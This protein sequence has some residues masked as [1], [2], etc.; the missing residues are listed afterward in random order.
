MTRS[1]SLTKLTGALETCA[2]R[3]VLSQIAPRSPQLRAHLQRRFSRPA[4]EPDGF[5]AEPVLEANFGWQRAEPTIADLAGSLLH[6]ALVE[7]MDRPPAG[8][9]REENR[10]AKTWSPYRHQ[11]AAWQALREEPAGS[12]LVSSGTGSGKTECFLVPVLDA[13]GREAEQQ[14]QPLVGVRALFLYPLNALI[15]SQRDR[16]RAWTH[17]FGGKLRFCLYNGET[18]EAIRRSDQR[19][20]VAEVLD[21]RTL[22]EDTPPILVT[23]TTMLEY[24]LVRRNDAPIIRAS[25]GQL[26]WIV[27]DEAH[28]YLGSQA[29]EL[30]LLLRRVLHAFD[31]SPEQVRFVATSATISSEGGSDVE[32]RLAD[33][34]AD[35]AGIPSASVSVITG[36]RRVP[37]LPPELAARDEALP[38]LDDLRRMAGAGR[39]SEL[40]EALASN[41]AVRAMRHEL[42]G[43]VEPNCKLTEL[44]QVVERHRGPGD[45]LLELLDLCACAKQGDE[46]LLPIRTH[47]FHRT[48]RGLWACCNPGCSGRGGTALDDPLWPFGKVFLDRWQECDEP[49]C[50]SKVFQL[51]LCRS[52]GSEYLLAEME[53]EEGRQRLVPATSDA[54]DEDLAADDMGDED[55]EAV[56]EAR[57]RKMSLRR[58]LTGPDA[59]LTGGLKELLCPISGELGAGDGDRHQVGL[60][61]TNVP[62]GRED[63]RVSCPSCNAHEYEPEQVF[64]P[65]RA[66]APFFLSSAIP[67]LL[68][69]L[70][71]P[72]WK[73][74]DPRP[75]NG[76]RL[77]T[78]SDS[79]QGTARFA[80]R[81]QSESERNYVRSWL[82]HQ[83]LAQRQIA[84]PQEI[85]STR[86]RI[87]AL[88][89]AGAT[90]NPALRG[91]LEAEQA[92][93]N[94]LT[95]PA[96]GR[97][98][99]RQA[100][101]DLKQD[102][103]IRRWLNKLWEDQAFGAVTRDKLPQL[104]LLR[105]L[106]RRPKW[107][108]SL[109]TLGL[110]A[111]EYPRCLEA[112]P[113]AA[114]R[115][116]GLPSRDWHDFLT[117]AVDHRVRAY[118]AVDVPE[119]FRHWL[120]VRI[121]PKVLL[122]PG[123][124][125]TANDQILWPLARKS[126]IRHRLTWLLAAGLELDLS[127]QEHRE[128]LSEL[129][130]AAWQ[131]IR[132]MLS[133][134]GGGW[135]LRLEDQV[136]LIE[137]QHAWRCPVTRRL[138]P[139]SFRGLTPYL[140]S[141]NSLAADCEKVA[142]P[143]VPRP[144]WRDE[145]DRRWSREEV[146]HWLDKDPSVVELRDR[147]LWSDLSDRL[148]AGVD[149]YRAA[150]HSAQQS[151][152]RLQELEKEFKDGRVNLLSCSTT[153]EMGVDIGG[154]S[155]VAMNNTPPSPANFLQRAGRAGR[156]GEAVAVSFTLCKATPHGE[157]VFEN[158]LW[159][160]RTPIYVPRVSLDSERIVERHVNAMVL[161][162][163]F[164]D[165]GSEVE[166]L[167]LDAGWFFG[168]DAV[169]TNT[170]AESFCDVCRSPEMLEDEKLK[171][172][173]R[174]LLRRTAHEDSPMEELL[175]QSASTIE[176][177]KLDFAKERDN[178]LKDLKSVQSRHTGK[179]TPEQKAIQF[180]LQRFLGEYL[181]SELASRGYLPGYGFPTHVVPFVHTTAKQFEAERRRRQEK[182]ARED[183]RALRRSYPSR[184]LSIALRD[185]APGNE[186]V[187]DGRVYRSEG[188]TLNWHVPPSD[189]EFREPQAFPVAWRC[190]DCHCS[191]TRPS[192]HEECPACGAGKDRL[193]QRSFL[194]PAGF[195]V[196]IR[197]Q[198]HNDLSYPP[199]LPVEEPWISAAGESWTDLPD[200]RWGSFRYSPR[201]HVFHYSKGV[202]GYGYAICLSCGRAESEVEPRPREG[203][204]PLP[205]ALPGHKRL[206]G[207][208][209]AEGT[210]LCPG[211]TETRLVKRWQWLGASARTDVFELQ[212]HRPTLEPR[213][214]AYSVAVA[215][216]EALAEK[217]GIDPREI[218]CAAIEGERQEG[219]PR[220]YSIVLYDT[221]SGGAGFV[222]AAA[223]HLPELLVAARD[224]L[225]DCP[226]RCNRA[227]HAC[228]LTYDSQ[229][230][231]DLLDRKI[232]YEA[233]SAEMIASL[234]LPRVQ[235]YFGSTSIAVFGTLPEAVR[236]EAQRQQI[237]QVEIFLGGDGSRWEIARWNLYRHLLGWAESKHVRLVLDRRALEQISPE[238]SWV[239]AGLTRVTGID[240]TSV[241]DLPAAPGGGVLLAR[242]GDGQQW[243]AWAS[244]SVT[245]TEPGEAW[246][247]LGDREFL[248][249]ADRLP[250]APIESNPVAMR[251]L[252]RPYPGTLI[253]MKILREL[254]GPVSRFGE[255]LWETLLKKAPSLNV[256]LNG[257]EP[258]A[259]ISYADRYLR[260][261]LTVKL[262]YEVVRALERRKGLPAADC[263]IELH[264][265]PPRANRPPRRACD[266]WVH[267]R[268]A[269]RVI[270]T[271]FG[272]RCQMRQT[273]I[274]EAPHWRELTLHFHNGR[275]WR[276]R[277]EQGFGFW[278]E[279]GYL[280]FPFER[281]AED[282]AKWLRKKQFS[283]GARSS[284]HS[285]A[286]YVFTPE[287]P[288]ASE[289]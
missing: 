73:D 236:R 49:T 153:M 179:E 154:L 85:E 120:G 46:R 100:C 224:R 215:L 208:R 240:L 171:Q 23:N 30:S 201:G 217:L 159:P 213:K 238:A 53:V 189:G 132:P 258:L 59:P 274:H 84:N 39:H 76:R 268:E 148:L 41:R 127:D 66:G 263:V 111:L 102:P 146:F 279:R 29:A 270:E 129:L 287:G 243:T 185:Y 2:A 34:L 15:N 11:L 12:V 45:H 260:S 43:G 6:P 252:R 218:G 186:V 108:N 237:R 10:F 157:A 3:A 239:L 56:R 9:L 52:C 119:G 181:L 90:T 26:R 89:A 176:S 135:R 163:F 169:V 206:R 187:L 225:A 219:E 204:S 63:V 277:L 193:L 21:R 69:H 60:V 133:E 282:Q 286:L 27:I 188:V 152:T 32:K 67:T 103:V 244:A 125:V 182:D 227:C 177:I 115:Q 5:L 165:L 220:A 1:I 271:L 242:V 50:G 264:S 141:A 68:E 221:A 247:A 232:A 110:L 151:G 93:L 216:R 275:Q 86:E 99:W 173:I 257:G 205:G 253:E 91:M 196:G 118:S 79:R 54:A 14:A 210:H 134:M 262:L 231:D 64:R 156:R 281:S 58:L 259:K 245:A 184:Q 178:L 158:P 36:N 106:A 202:A 197:Y 276:L 107:L 142:I 4:G 285:T 284:H 267:A 80:M 35:L 19:R 283:V 144:R 170:P 241:G 266:D 47:I 18:P 209:E 98:S 16:L 230:Q 81:A 62:R 194:Q 112:T 28:T 200:H 261:P 272:D 139:R 7:A 233:L 130:D 122:G 8:P 278:N 101:D 124:E 288:P 207:G 42:A 140:T 265:T 195:A 166:T 95:R 94:R 223:E 289:K 138:L 72:E 77:I 31:V 44:Q 126:P 13:L 229:Y 25:R 147:G 255:Q 75:S 145:R 74:D 113:P 78:F 37:E 198:P 162:R 167:K 199:Y 117:L 172:G 22:R 269:R 131:A 203:E 149:Y 235:Q 191:G 246:G 228:L 82:Y 123:A 61:V 38:A 136:D 105:E 280:N 249:R 17:G 256:L 192:Q 234:S 97:L 128:L 254:D 174:R 88:E 114:W 175:E 248:V 70:P 273:S 121:R 87:Q 40:F 83:V 212:L 150:E 180:Q 92:K 51:A 160:F 161:A 222:A 164:A 226:R 190:R 48:A 251:D 109:E 55:D 137:T 104:L 20:S 116:R 57:N 250:D 96:Y 214:A 65:A 33:F 183:N 168:R 71:D 143:R 24:M 211:G 155:M